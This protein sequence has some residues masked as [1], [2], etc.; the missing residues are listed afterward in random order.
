M[1]DGV[2]T[3]ILVG[4]LGQDPDIKIM[5]D[6]S[7]M[8]NLSVATAESWK[9]KTT[10]ERRT[11]TEWHRV[12]VFN[13]VLSGLLESYAKKGAKVYIS[14][15]LTTRQYKDKDGIDRYTTE[16]LISRFRGEVRILDSNSG[17]G[18]QSFA[19]TSS[20]ANNSFA[21]TTSATTNNS[22]TDFDI[23]SLDDEEIPF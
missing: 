13:P 5:Q 11:K 12:V 23:D 8:A 19:G 17:G 10:N 9:D 3:V 4:N 21:K 1:W 7:K 22:N 18:N 15:S 20:G 16:V 14:G 2:N 6:G